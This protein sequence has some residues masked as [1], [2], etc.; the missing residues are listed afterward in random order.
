VDFK[1]KT[2]P[3]NRTIVIDNCKNKKEMSTALD[4]KI[5]D[6]LCKELSIDDNYQ[7]IDGRE[8][9]TSQIEIIILQSH[10]NL[11]NEMYNEF[12]AACLITKCD[13]L[14]NKIKELTK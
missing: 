10:I 9:A 1:K 5:M 7:C 2:K 14:N 4:K 6:I 12:P 11:L 3:P 8:K 13:E